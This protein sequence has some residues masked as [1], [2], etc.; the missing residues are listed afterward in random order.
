MWRDA[1]AKAQ[2]ESAAWPYGWVEGVDYPH[3]A[4][5]ATV[6]GKITL[7]DPQAPD[8]VISNLLVGL[9]AP[10]Y[11]PATISRGR[12]MFGGGFGPGGGGDDETNY[13]RNFNGTNYFA[14]AGTNN[15][16]ARERFGRGGFNAGPKIVDWQNDAKNYE[17][18]VSASPDG[19]FSIPNVR[20][21]T[22]TLHAIADGVLGDFSYSNV[23]VT[24]G[25]NLDL[26]K[27]AWH[28]VRYGR[29]LWDI[30]IPNRS[31]AEFLDGN[32]YFHWGWYLAYAK[33][34]PNDVNYVIGKSDF[35]KDWFFEQVPHNE[36]PDNRT[37]SGQGRSTT[38][39]IRFDLPDAPHGLATLRL[40]ICGIGTRSLPATMNGQSIGNLR[41][42]VY[43]ATINRDGIAGYWSE[44]DLAFDASLMK[45]GE[46]ILRLTVSAG[47]LMNG[48]I[49]DYLRLELNENAPGK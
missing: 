11:A 46:N 22:Y 47:G 45:S 1:L 29:Q 17:F 5:R 31:G 33:L 48:I 18:W 34:F 13:L 41:G 26:G 8:L 27:L 4:E 23:T 16:R 21:G 24:A 42:L 49:Y 32:D 3:R 36:N 19:T 20:A 25:Q 43:N 12:G 7:N 38:W 37:G 15:A 28:P 10:D 14:R 39:T 40:A 2:S 30:G 44:H 9:T 6:T 35:H